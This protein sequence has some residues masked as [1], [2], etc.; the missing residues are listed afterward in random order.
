MAWQG[1]CVAPLALGTLA[2]P[3]AA[4]AGAR[5]GA[6]AQLGIR[7]GG[8]QGLSVTPHCPLELVEILRSALRQLL[9]HR[10]VQH[11]TPSTPSPT[12]QARTNA[13]QRQR[14]SEHPATSARS[15]QRAHAAH[16]PRPRL[17]HI[18]QKGALTG[19]LSPELDLQ[20]SLHHFD[21]RFTE[22]SPPSPAGSSPTPRACRRVASPP[23]IVSADIPALSQPP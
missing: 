17:A 20:Q 1:F 12:P 13:G 5:W 21:H 15:V 8:A 4:P 3:R 9:C 22:H 11:T 23:P 14:T 10:Q 7:S 19:S 16:A 2:H 18:A 6:L